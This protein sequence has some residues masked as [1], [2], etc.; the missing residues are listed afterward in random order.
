MNVTVTPVEVDITKR[1][2]LYQVVIELSSTSI[3]LINPSL[4]SLLA[5]FAINCTGDAKTLRSPS[6][7]EVI[8]TP[9]TIE[10]PNE[11]GTTPGPSAQQTTPSSP[12]FTPVN[13]DTR[14]PL[15]PSLACFTTFILALVFILVNVPVSPILGF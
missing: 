3:T 10:S 1:V 8:A 5:C 2:L 11:P 9:T 14:T 4:H 13:S 12:S 6:D 15:P 7:P